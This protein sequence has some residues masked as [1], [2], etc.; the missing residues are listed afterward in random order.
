MISMHLHACKISR[1]SDHSTTNSCRFRAAR[2]PCVGRAAP[3]NAIVLAQGGAIKSIGRPAG[4]RRRT[5]DGV[6]VARF[7]RRTCCTAAGRYMQPQP[8]LTSGDRQHCCRTTAAASAV[9]SPRICRLP[10]A[11][12]TCS[13]LVNKSAPL[14]LIPFNHARHLKK[15]NFGSGARLIAIYELH[16]KETR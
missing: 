13:R 2:V 8:L 15:L 4:S 16:A 10:L 5:M 7:A 12:H 14:L 1:C 6:Q 11:K 3:S 9:A